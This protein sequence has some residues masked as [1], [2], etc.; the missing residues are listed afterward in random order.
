MGC[1]I[2]PSSKIEVSRRCFDA[3]LFIYP[4]CVRVWGSEQG[5]LVVCKVLGVFR[6]DDTGFMLG[7]FASALSLLRSASYN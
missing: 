2:D 6:M 3:L 7:C 1:L 4:W 5:G